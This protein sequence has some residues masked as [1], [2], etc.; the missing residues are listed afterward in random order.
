M[1]IKNTLVEYSNVV[2][3]SKG[4]S[5]TKN[6]QAAFPNSPIYKGEVSDTERAKFYQEKVLDAENVTGMSVVNYSMNYDN[7][8]PNLDDVE[9]GGEGKPATPYSPNV[10]SP[11]PGST[12]AATQPEFT[13][14]T[15]DINTISNFGT[16]LGGLVSPSSTT[17]NISKT[18][19]GEYISGRSF[20]GSDGQS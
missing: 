17:S 2:L 14:E 9:T 11:G 4:T 5:N 1:S 16:G 15:K 13:G 7:G 3:K 12:S 6:L 18:K 20:Q 19:I 10:T 8:V